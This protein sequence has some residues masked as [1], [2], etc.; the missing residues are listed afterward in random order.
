[1]SHLQYESEFSLLLILNCWVA[2]TYQQF[3]VTLAE[4]SD[5]SHTR[6]PSDSTA[7]FLHVWLVLLCL[8]SHRC[9][10]SETKSLNQEV[11]PARPSLPL[12]LPVTERVRQKHIG[13]A[14]ERW[15]PLHWLRIKLA[16]IYDFHI[17]WSFILWPIN[18]FIRVNSAKVCVSL[19]PLSQDRAGRGLSADVP[20]GLGLLD[21]A[22]PPEQNQAA[23]PGGPHEE[24]QDVTH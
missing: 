23:V 17:G 9:V 5:L 12:L 14:E 20:G 6:Q 19:Q 3:H 15:A 21:G 24:P 11:K 16:L 4:N 18:T 1:M 2:T 13:G 10:L 8:T 7:A 22:G